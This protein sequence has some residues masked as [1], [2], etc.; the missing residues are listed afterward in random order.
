MTTEEKIKRLED[1]IEQLERRLAALEGK[2]AG[3]TDRQKLPVNKIAYSKAFDAWCNGDRKAMKEY[4][5]YY[6]IPT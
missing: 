4:C 6:R 1:R 2:P 5:R 3:K